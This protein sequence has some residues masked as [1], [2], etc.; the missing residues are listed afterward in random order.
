M[1]KTAKL[2]IYLVRAFVLIVLSLSGSSVMDYIFSITVNSSSV[3]SIH[4][5]I[6]KRSW[7]PKRPKSTTQDWLVIIFCLFNTDK[8]VRQDGPSTFQGSKWFCM[9]FMRKFNSSWHWIPREK[10]MVD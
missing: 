7:A 9:Y 6:W 4:Y 3:I 10:Y 5:N 2:V 1:S 8:T